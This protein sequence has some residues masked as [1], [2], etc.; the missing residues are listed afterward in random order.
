MK[1]LDFGVVLHDEATLAFCPPFET[2]H[3][4]LRERAEKIADLA[5][6][7]RFLQSVPENARTLE[8]ARSLGLSA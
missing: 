5:L 7:A 3:R 8:L 6:R 1:I 2:S 4:L